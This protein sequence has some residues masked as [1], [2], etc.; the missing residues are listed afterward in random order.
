[1]KN[2][3]L[4]FLTNL[5]PFILGCAHH[6]P[7]VRVTGW[8]TCS[9]HGAEGKIETDTTCAGGW[10]PALHVESSLHAIP[11]LTSHFLPHA[12]TYINMHIYIYIYPFTATL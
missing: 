4:S 9:I 6:I 7:G 1:M 2:M 11:S 3:I 8:C 10:C 12:H 5:F